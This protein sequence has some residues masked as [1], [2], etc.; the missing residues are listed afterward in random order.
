MQA[1]LLLIEDDTTLRWMLARTLRKA[2]YQVTEA[3]DGDAAIA[4]LHQASAGA[5]PYHVVL[6]DI[7]MGATNG[8]QVTE[9]A[10]QQPDAPEVILLTAHGTLDTAVAALRHGAFDYLLKPV[11]TPHLLE[12]IAAAVKQR[13]AR[14]HRDREAT[15]LRQVKDIL[16]QIQTDRPLPLELH[17]APSPPEPPRYRRIGALAIDTYRREVWY[18]DQPIHRTPIEYAIL[19]CLA[20]TPHQVVPYDDIVIATHGQR[21]APEE[22]RKLLTTHIRN[23]RRKLDPRLIVGVRSMGYMLTDADE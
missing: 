9:T 15:V 16:E 12:R 22:A 4:L 11:E 20:Q 5:D 2:G 3:P 14:R 19:D 6:T 23:L 17:V 18:R 1:H 13:T 7:V 8:V 21:V 10:I